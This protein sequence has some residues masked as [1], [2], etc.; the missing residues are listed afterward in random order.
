MHRAA[1]YVVMPIIAVLGLS[2]VATAQAP[3]LD[4]TDPVGAGAPELLQPVN[5][6][7]GT[8]VGDKLIDPGELTW[9]G[10]VR[11]IRGKVAELTT[12]W[13][14][15]GLP[16]TVQSIWNSDEYEVPGAFG[17]AK[18]H[19]GT[20]LF[21][22]EG[23]AWVGPFAGLE[24]VDGATDLQATLVGT[25]SYYGQCAILNVIWSQAHAWEMDGMVF[26]CQSLQVMQ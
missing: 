23:G 10:N 24:Y 7:T 17:R 12:H 1:P 2:A 13:S 18:I 22:D 3:P 26:D 16:S 8:V 11:Q 25:E 5:Q 15:P 20:F 6:V 9:Q 4:A 21:R 19:A 14:S